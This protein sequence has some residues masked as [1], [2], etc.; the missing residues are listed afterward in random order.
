M[1]QASHKTLVVSLLK[2]FRDS[3]ASQAPYCEKDLKK[4]Q[5]IWVFIIFA[6]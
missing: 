2:S 6:T 1:G 5:K 4:F 3:L